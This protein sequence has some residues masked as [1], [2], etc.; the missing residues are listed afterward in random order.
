MNG[1]EASPQEAN[2]LKKKYLRQTLV[3][4]LFCLVS[5]GM[6]VW[7]CVRVVQAVRSD[8]G[9]GYIC[10]YAVMLLVYLAFLG[11]MG[12]FHVRGEYRRYRCVKRGRICII[13]GAA[14]R[15]GADRASDV[16]RLTGTRLL[17]DF[18]YDKDL[19]REWIEPRS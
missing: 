10:Y 16:G 1:R 19:G 2:Y 8:A 6:A 13:E 7:M 12:I 17:V 3:M 9:W 4:G 15:S 14:E 5:A 18:P 11:Y